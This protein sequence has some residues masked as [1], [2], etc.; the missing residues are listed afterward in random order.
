MVKARAAI[1]VKHAVFKNKKYLSLSLNCNDSPRLDA[2]T[3]TQ[4]A[5]RAPQKVKRKRPYIYICLVLTTTATDIE[6][7]AAPP[8]RRATRLRHC[9]GVTTRDCALCCPAPRRVSISV[10]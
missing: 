3:A 6:R 7:P 8:R 1:V 10:C 5:P 2:L 4:S 9:P